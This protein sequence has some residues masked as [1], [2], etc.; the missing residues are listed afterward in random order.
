MDDISPFR[1]G[2]RE[3]SSLSQSS[4]KFEI[5]IAY[6]SPFSFTCVC[7]CLFVCFFILRFVFCSYLGIDTPQRELDLR[8]KGPN[9][10]SGFVGPSV[11]ERCVGSRS[12][13]SPPIGGKD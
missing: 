5:P 2:Q 9:G 10:S 7:V 13:R 3:F 6:F 1:R 8:G 4:L 11:Q 12:L